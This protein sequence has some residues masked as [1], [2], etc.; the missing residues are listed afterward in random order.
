MIVDDA[1]ISRLS[2]ERVMRRLGTTT[3]WA[4]NGVEA[5]S[6]LEKLPF[7]GILIDGQMPI[8]DGYETTRRIRL[9]ELMTGA[10][11]LFIILA[12]GDS[13]HASRAMEAGMDASIQKPIDETE[14]LETIA[15]FGKCGGRRGV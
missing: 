14:L 10:N 8:M 7:D 2:A 6:L 5:L 11:R 13:D 3:D 15:R 9:R 12:T 4:C 1:E